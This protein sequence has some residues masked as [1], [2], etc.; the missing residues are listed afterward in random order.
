M[1][2]GARF[3]RCGKAPCGKLPHGAFFRSVSRAA[4]LPRLFAFDRGRAIAHSGETDRRLD[5]LP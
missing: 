5:A 4:A 1:S 2:I 3:V